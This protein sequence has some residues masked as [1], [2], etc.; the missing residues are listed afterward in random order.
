M[1]YG[2]D[3]L[4][5]GD[6]LVDLYQL[7]KLKERNNKNSDDYWFEK[8]KGECKFQPTT[9]KSIYYDQKTEAPAV[10]GLDKARKRM[11]KA[12]EEAEFKKKMTERSTF[13]ATVGVK[14]AKKL[15]KKG[16]I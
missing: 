15:I 1:F 3:K 10:K 4:T 12:R 6:H 14:K 9:N 13:S 5:S 2:Q 16:Q 7:S 8:D 11:Q